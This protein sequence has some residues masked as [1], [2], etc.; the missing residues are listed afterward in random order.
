[1]IKKIIIGITLFVVLVFAALLAAPFLFKDQIVEKVKTIINKNV[2]AKVNFDEV[3]IGIIKSFPNLNFG[4]TNLQIIGIDTFA[5]DTL[6]KMKEL[7]VVVDIMTVIKKQPIVVKS[8]E[9]TEPYLYVRVLKNGKANYDI[10]KAVSNATE[11]LDTASNPFKVGLQ[12]YSIKS[13]NLRYDDAS[14]GFDML[15]KNFDHKGTGDFTQDLFT[16]T[17]ESGIDQL[18]VSYGG[19]NY[20]VKTKTKAKVPI[21]IDMPNMKFTFTDNE[22]E[23]NELILKFAGTIAMP[24][25][26]IAM[27]ITFDA[28]KSD[29][30]NFLSLIPAVYASSFDKLTANG[31]FAINGFAKGIYN[32]KS[33][34]SFD[35]NMLIEN[36][37]FK[38]PDLPKGI[39]NVQVSA[40]ISNKDGNLN[41]TIVSIPKGHIEFGT[42]PFDFRLLLKTPTTDPDINMAVKGKID[43]A[44]ITR[45]IPLEGTK[46]EGVLN[47]DVQ[48]KGKMSAV[49]NGNYDQFYSAGTLSVVNLLYQSKDV[50]EAVNIPSA[51]FTFNPKNITVTN[52][53]AKVGK[54]DFKATGTLDNYLGYLFKEQPIK[55]NFMLKS[56]VIDVNEL[57]GS[58]T[59]TTTTN[60]E[61]APLE[62]VEVP[63]N[64]DFVLKSD[65]AKVLYDN[66]I[67]E[68][69]TGEI[70]VRNS[71]IN[72]NSVKLNTLGAAIA[73]NGNYTSID[74]EKPA[75][76]LDLGIQ[77]LDIQKAFTTFSTVKAMAPIAK[78]TTG[79]FNGTMNFSTD[80][81][82]DM[83][84][85]MNTVGAK[86]TLNILKAIV[87]GFEPLNKLASQLKMDKYK[88]LNINNAKIDFVVNNGK[89][90]ISPF[91]IK[92][93]NMNMNVAGSSGFDQSLDYVLKL[94]FPRAELGN[95]ANEVVSNLTAKLN[96]QGVNYNAAENLN[97]N[98][99]IGG[100]ITN[101]TVKISMADLAG[102][103][104][105][106]VTDAID[107]KRKEL[108]G[109]AKAETERLKA[110]GLAK[111]KELENKGR[112]EAD[113]I[114]AEAQTKAKAETDRLKE[115]ARKKSEEAKKKAEEE[116]KKKLKD[117]FKK[118]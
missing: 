28:A 64:I 92:Q 91:D 59:A 109:K 41:N 89:V 115:E 7:Y 80:F 42:D 78:Y 19:V 90:I 82:K 113:R 33:L 88:Q 114:K 55:G 81:G 14:L 24:S 75:M 39:N 68:N 67:F 110:E 93:G 57:M 18:S 47:A 73:M 72:F 8:F 48:A 45:M 3:N 99:L 86:G 15:L 71:A 52:L 112:A 38:Y 4:L 96:K 87:G 84:P 53:D 50:P 26:D 77:N 118:P 16:L 31:K 49:E 22:I 5:T 36:G 2:N 61:S 69:L 10:V 105:D 60:E 9:L 20:L 51:A 12:S 79:L 94:K 102:G 46:L 25:D 65:L 21:A 30:K 32:E 54:S 35:I 62:I 34:P 23:L 108:E 17:T 116:A 29:F 43:L 27:D 74:P 1:M 97:V 44:E 83:M 76:N 66:Q 70:V 63:A 40:N 107:A 37:S 85:L 106:A 101:P 104:K 95:Q 58:E 100:S 117:L 103:L 111:A 6:V 56:N 11:S 13:G 98:A